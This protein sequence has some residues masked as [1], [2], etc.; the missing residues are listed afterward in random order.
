MSGILRLI[1]SVLRCRRP[2]K[3]AVS[4]ERIRR[5]LGLRE[6]PRSAVPAPRNT[7]SQF[8]YSPAGRGKPAFGTRR[9]VLPFPKQP[10]VLRSGGERRA[11]TEHVAKSPIKADQL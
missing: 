1:A 6:Q 11:T 5:V 7:S 4:A 2:D 8:G 3:E 10:G 9:K